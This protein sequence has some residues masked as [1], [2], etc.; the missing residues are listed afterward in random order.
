MLKSENN[1]KTLPKGI[2]NTL[3]DTN[4]EEEIEHNVISSLFKVLGGNAQ[5]EALIS[6]KKY[7][8][9]TDHSNTDF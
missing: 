4:P 3:R 6:C 9:D 5:N 2:F 7:M 1:A 8:V